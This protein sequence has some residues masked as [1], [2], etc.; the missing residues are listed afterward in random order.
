LHDGTI[1]RADFQ[2]TGYWVLKIGFR[3][4][5]GKVGWFFG[6]R[7]EF[8][9]PALPLGWGTVGTV[10]F[11]LPFLTMTVLLAGMAAIKWLN[12]VLP[13]VQ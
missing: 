9:F 11:V 7:P 10:L 12:L 6:R 5:P 13:T 2:V 4:L 8:Y 3:W 1:Y